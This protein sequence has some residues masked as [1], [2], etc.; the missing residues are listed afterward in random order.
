MNLSIPKH[1][2]LTWGH[3]LDKS[4]GNVLVYQG[5]I[6]YSPNSSCLVSLPPNDSTISTEHTIFTQTSTRDDFIKPYWWTEKFVWLAFIPCKP[7]Y[8]CLLLERLATVPQHFHHYVENGQ[9]K[10]FLPPEIKDLSIKLDWWLLCATSILAKEFNALVVRPFSP[11]AL[12]YNALHS[13]HGQ[14]MSQVYRSRAWF[15]VW[16]G[17]LSYLIAKVKSANPSG[18][19]VGTYWQRA[20]CQNGFTFDTIDAVYALSVCNF[21]SNTERA[22]IFLDLISSD[23]SQPCQLV[24]KI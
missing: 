8:S 2:F 7:L 1:F 23:M 18:I 5:D 3:R 4:S 22:G 24:F 14:M 20:L 9:D 21:S 10:Y 13:M 17:L 15:K 12:G 6:Y 19:G 16:M 11:W